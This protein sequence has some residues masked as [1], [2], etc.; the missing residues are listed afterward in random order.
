[1]TNSKISVDPELIE[2][3]K[4]ELNLDELKKKATH[5]NGEGQYYYDKR[6]K[7]WQYKFYVYDC[8]DGTRIRKCVSGKT[9]E[10]AFKKYKQLMFQSND[11]KFITKHGLPLIE[12]IRKH[13]QQRYEAND[14]SPGYYRRTLDTIRIIENSSIGELNIQDISYMQLQ[15]FFNELSHKYSDSSIKKVW[16]QVAQ[17]FKFAVKSKFIQD[18]PMEDVIKPKSRLEKK[19]LSALSLTEHKI[20]SQYLLKSKI[21]EEKYKNVFLLQL[22]LGLRV[23]EALALKSTDINLDNDTIQISRTLTTN[24]TGAV[25]MGKSTKTA[26]GKRLLPIPQFLKEHIIEQLEYSKNNKDNLLFTYGDK[27]V[28]PHSMNSQLKR[29]CKNLN[30]MRPRNLNTY[31]KTFLCNSFDR[32]WYACCCIAKING[33][34]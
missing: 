14:I 4:K 30:I 6:Y 25:I 3:I 21:S 24:E 31:F 12:L 2:A 19:E 29:M 27:L 9:K 33:T 1:M 20:L 5:S 34:F 18:N 17:S 10:E 22:Y 15:K 26:T 11:F 7:S 8:I 32:S 13:L 28:H 23:G 16:E